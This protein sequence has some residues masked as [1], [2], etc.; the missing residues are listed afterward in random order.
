VKCRQ[1]RPSADAEDDDAARRLW[2]DTV[3]L[4]GTP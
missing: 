3:R 4:A 2:D 1:T